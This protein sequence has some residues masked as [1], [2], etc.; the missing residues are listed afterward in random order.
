MRSIVATLALA[1]A[2]V[3]AASIPD[4][5]KGIDPNA[6]GTLLSSMFSA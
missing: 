6:K 1:C 2:C 5:Y 3:S 4:Y